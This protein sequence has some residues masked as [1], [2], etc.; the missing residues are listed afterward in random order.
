MICWKG[1]SFAGSS[2]NL[3]NLR[4]FPS[5]DA[6]SVR[7]FALVDTALT[8]FIVGTAVLFIGR[9]CRHRLRR[10]PLRRQLGRHRLAHGH[11]P[12]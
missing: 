6:G 2:A 4:T 3:T 5:P 1:R 11:Q 9:V 12:T 10:S 7:K 8:V